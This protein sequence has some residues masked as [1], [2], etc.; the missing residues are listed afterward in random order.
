[1]GQL[2]KEPTSWSLTYTVKKLSET[3]GQITMTP[4]IYEV[5]IIS[6]HFFLSVLDVTL[7]IYYNT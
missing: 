5:L 4:T 3:V 1:M 2:A 7:K 6:L